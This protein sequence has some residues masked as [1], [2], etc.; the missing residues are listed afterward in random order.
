MRLTERDLRRIETRLQATRT[1]QTDDAV[2]LPFYSD[3]IK[4]IETIREE[5]EAMRMMKQFMA[6]QIELI[7]TYVAH[8]GVRR[9]LPRP[10]GGG[11]STE[12]SEGLE[13]G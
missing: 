1:K 12:S 13:R 8:K 6:T 9:I 10:Q 3:L 4:L 2:D 7:D 5:R 11:A